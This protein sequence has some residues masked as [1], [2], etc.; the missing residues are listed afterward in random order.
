A[1]SSPIPAQISAT[2]IPTIGPPPSATAQDSAD[3]EPTQAPLVVIPTISANATIVG[4]VIGP[5]YTLPPTSTP[6]PTDAPTAGPQ[7][8]DAP[9]DEGEGDDASS[10]AAAPPE[11]TTVRPVGT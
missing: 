8:T 3:E 7:P 5:D 9:D 11:P 1:V 10:Q 6:R 4:P 2:P